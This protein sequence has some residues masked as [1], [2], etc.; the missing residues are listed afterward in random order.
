MI[1][2]EIQRPSRALRPLCPPVRREDRADGSRR[3]RPEA[4]GQRSGPVHHRRQS[5]LPFGSPPPPSG[6]SEKF[7]CEGRPCDKGGNAQRHAR[8]Q[9]D[10]RARPPAHALLPAPSLPRDPHVGSRPNRLLPAERSA[11]EAILQASTK[12]RLA[13]PTPHAP[14]ERLRET[15]ARSGCL[16]LA[17]T[18]G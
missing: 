5:A 2:C 7:G 3:M 6:P 9:R 4:R 11:A 12:I 10:A 8:Q 1:S 14:E 18:N 16:L 15:A 17:C 13:R